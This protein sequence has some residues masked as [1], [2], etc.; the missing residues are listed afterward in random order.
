MGMR[1]VLL[2]SGGEGVQGWGWVS[3]VGI[4]SRFLHLLVF[5]FVDAV[6]W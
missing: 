2:C 4:I 3:D 1:L 6:G 5:V